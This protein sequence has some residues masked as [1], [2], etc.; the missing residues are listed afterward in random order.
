MKCTNRVQ[1]SVFSLL[2]HEGA[3][4]ESIITATIILSGFI[5]EILPPFQKYEPVMNHWF[6]APTVKLQTHNKEK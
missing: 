6:F 5:M 1:N 3:I 4:V 2:D